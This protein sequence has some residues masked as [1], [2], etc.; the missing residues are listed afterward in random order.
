[1]YA[2][3]VRTFLEVGAG[4]TLTDLVGQ[5]LGDRPH[6]AI[7]LDPGT[8][9]GVTSLQDALG[10]LAVGGV[11]MDFAA[12]WADVAPAAATPPGDP[13]KLTVRI[14][15]G[16]YGRPYPPPERGSAPSPATGAQR[17]AAGRSDGHGRWDAGENHQHAGDQANAS[18]P[19]HRVPASE[20]SVRAT[21]PDVLAAES[22]ALA[23]APSIRA[24]EPSI[25]AAQSDVLMAQ[26]DDRAT[27]PSVPAAEPSVRVAN[28]D[29]LAV[30]PSVRAAEPSVRTAEPYVPAAA[31]EPLPAPSRADRAPTGPEVG[32][33]RVIEQTQQQAADAH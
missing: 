31:P 25:R 6:A 12:L 23:V 30:A 33:L 16:N 4:A 13:P 18:A 32:W 24:T 7:S 2:R 20:P 8:R 22:D 28:S 19:P 21:Q 14:D 27:E 29:V 9:H 15:G 3:G 26:S 1:I 11:A 5:I 17:A 10:R